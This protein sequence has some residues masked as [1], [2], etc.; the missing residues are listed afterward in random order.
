MF[1][2]Q[3]HHHMLQAL[4]LAKK[5]CATVSPNPMVG[6]IIVKNNEIMGQG[7]HQRA[8]EPHAEVFALREAGGDAKGATL[9][10]TLEPCCHTGKTPPCT[11]AII[12]SGI[13]KVMIAC[14]DPNPLVAGKGIAALEAAGIA[15]SVGCC[16]TQARAL[17]KIFFHFIQ[18][19]KPFVMAKWAMSLDGKTITSINDSRK[20]SG[21]AAH[22]HC[23]QLRHQADAIVVGANTV[24]RDDPQL[25]VRFFDDMQKKPVRVI[26]C[27][28]T[29]F[30]ADLNIFQDGK[31]MLV[32]TEKN[33]ALFTPPVSENVELLIVPEKNNRADIA[34]LLDLLGKRNITSVLVEGGMT[35]L[36]DFFQKD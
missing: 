33:N 36:Q 11:N 24:L 12:Q 14:L 2:D 29:P 16:E 6:A 10:V 26:L 28:H 30:S 4:A 7:F 23:H 8:G 5:G 22:K 15:V 1:S 3:D 31:T 20:I 35:V 17:N 34:V 13:Q 21:E 9:Y 32:V 25:T 19:K 27:G 18:H